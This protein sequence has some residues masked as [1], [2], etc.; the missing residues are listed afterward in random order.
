MST[1]PRTPVSP[2]PAGAPMVGLLKS[3]VLA[4]NDDGRWQNGLA[5]EPEGCVTGQ[6][7]D[8][9]EPADILAPEK[10]ATV[11]W[12]PYV[13]SVSE[14]CS[15]FSDI[16]DRGARVRRLMSS[17]E[18][19]LIAHE[20]WT[21]DLASGAFLPDGTTPWPNSWLSKFGDYDDL[22]ETGPVAHV[23]ALAC[24]QQYLADNNG[25]QQGMIHATSQTI[26]HWESFRLLRREG[27]RILTMQDNIVVPSPGYPGTDHQGNIGDGNIWAFATDMVR[28]WLG[29]VQTFDRDD[30]IDRRN[31]TIV[32]VASRFALAEW[33]RCRHAGIQ[34]DQ[35]VCAAGGS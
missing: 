9:C 32:A 19:S 25:G 34:L 8:P 2:L 4:G 16:T 11:E 18:E 28:V 13:I 1:G 27:N 14:E 26:T 3:A 10:P 35:Q 7:L 15:T 30:M 33:Q 12:E 20:L 5:Y 6:T 29:P 17:M 22:S 21:G 24:L 23:H 31:N